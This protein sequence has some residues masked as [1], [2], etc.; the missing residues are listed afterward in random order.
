MGVERCLLIQYSI[1]HSVQGKNAFL[2]GI[3]VMAVVTM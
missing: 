3:V 1:L 2:G